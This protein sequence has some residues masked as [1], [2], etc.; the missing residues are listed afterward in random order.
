MGTRGETW[1]VKILLL[2][3]VA[4]GLGAAIT[5]GKVVPDVNRYLRI[6]R[7]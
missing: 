3:A 6:R 4:V 7:M 2:A 1:Q 5:A